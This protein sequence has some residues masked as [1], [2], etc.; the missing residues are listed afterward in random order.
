MTLQLLVKQATCLSVCL[1]VQELQCDVS[2]EEDSRQEWTFTL[3]DFDN[4][5]KVT[6]EVGVLPARWQPSGTR[7]GLSLSLL[8]PPPGAR[9]RKGLVEKGFWQCPAGCAVP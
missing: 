4:N 5:G 2:V 6:R 3:Y 1:S 8:P 7:A 9:A